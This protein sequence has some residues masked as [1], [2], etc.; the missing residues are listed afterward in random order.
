ML[1]RT[2]LKRANSIAQIPIAWYDSDEAST[3]KDLEPYVPMLNRMIE[4]YEHYLPTHSEAEDFKIFIRA[5]TNES[6][7]TLIHNIP[8][9]IKTWDPVND[10][11]FN[12]VTTDQLRKCA[13]MQ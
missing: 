3:T 9:E 7:N 12:K 6:W 2:E 13:H 1:L 4:F 5:L 10:I 8:E 11:Q